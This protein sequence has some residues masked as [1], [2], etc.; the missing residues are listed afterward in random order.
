VLSNASRESADE[1]GGEHE[2]QKRHGIRGI[3]GRIELGLA[4][5]EVALHD[6]GRQRDEDGLPKAAEQGCWDHD[7]Q[8]KK[9]RDRKQ[10]LE[11]VREQS[12]KAN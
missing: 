10:P 4:G 12:D 6:Y 5:S 1:Q 3:G 8:A 2:G 7:E 9:S 11:P